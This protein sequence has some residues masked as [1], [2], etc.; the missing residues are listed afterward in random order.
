MPFSYA[1][2]AFNVA[3]GSQLNCSLYGDKMHIILFNGSE[4]SQ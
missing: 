1:L 4:K 3:Q 2:S